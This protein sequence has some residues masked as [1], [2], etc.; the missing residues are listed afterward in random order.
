M[1]LGRKGIVSGGGA[2][3]I[4]AAMVVVMVQA[5]ACLVLG[6]GRTLTAYTFLNLFLLTTVATALAAFNAVKG[7]SVSR[8]FWVLYAL[9]VG[10]WGFNQALWIYYQFW[11]N[12]QVPNESIAEPALFLHTVPL[13]AA[14]AMQPHLDP[15]SR[16]LHQTTF[17]FLLLLCFWV[18]L[19]AYYVFPHQFLFPDPQSYWFRYNALYFVENLVLLLALGA[20]ILCSEGTWKSIYFYLLSATGIYALT[21]LQ[22]NVS[23]NTGKPCYVGDVHDWGFVAAACGLILTAW[24]GRKLSPASY[25]PRPLNTR[26]AK[27]AAV[28]SILG[29]AMVPMMG[30][31]ALYCGDASTALLWA[32]LMII[33]VFA[34]IFAALVFLQMYAANL[35]LH[36]EIG[37]RVKAEQELRE[38]TATAQAANRAKAEFLANM[39]H[40]IR[41]PMNGILGL[42]GLVLE[43]PL[44]P[45]QRDYLQ[46]AKSSADSLMTILND[47]LDFSKVDAGKLTIESVTFDLRD[48]V[49]QSLAI[50]GH[51][52]ETSG[53][54]LGCDVGPEVPTRVVGDPTRLRQVIVNLVGNAF[55]FTQKG[56][57]ALQVRKE[58][59]AAAE[60]RLHFSVRDTGVGIPK[61][62]QKLIFAPFSQA[63]GSITRKWGGTGLGL[64]ISARLV[65]LM[66]GA[67]WVDS[68][69]GL[70]STFHFTVCFSI[71]DAH[72]SPLLETLSSNSS[73][74]AGPVAGIAAGTPCRKLTIL[75]AEDNVI[76]QRLA[77]RLLEKHGHQVHLAG[78]GRQALA[79][80]KQGRYDLVLM[81]VQMP[82]MDGTEATAVIR[83]EERSTGE[84]LPVVAM[85]AHSMKGDREAYLAAGMDGYV[86]KPINSDE[87]FA[88][89]AEVTRHWEAPPA[90]NSA[91]SLRECA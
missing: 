5:A 76:N 14:L 7:G 36:R 46:M 39:S 89:I 13:M 71:A 22:V 55:K 61:E 66:G 42:T 90:S 1:S 21:S 63:D 57:V 12:R 48:V 40:E 64:T 68:Q 15:G 17:S 77:L 19:Y 16:R 24:E 80:L 28:L 91:S 9:G 11:L 87:L 70:G 34:I 59:C 86:S 60:L 44:T 58:S 62:K 20:L 32:H 82:E 30:I 49:A 56:E 3:G 18:F 50:F 37:V 53:L 69:P 8:S 74:S 88:V 6:P 38:A 26:L 27:Y 84:H 43:T 85:T 2:R 65:E 72:P 4:I 33:L 23:I 54:K 45:E 79:A 75:L 10:L 31:W 81:D 83:T 78:T 25:R 41:T 52:A 47:I 35:D 29:V 73:A 51:R 67:I